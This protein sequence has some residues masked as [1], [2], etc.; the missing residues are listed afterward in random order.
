MWYQHTIVLHAK[1]RGF[2]LV[3]D[4]IIEKL[5]QLASVEV[6]ILHLLL[7]HLSYDYQPWGVLPQSVHPYL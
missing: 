2:H 6:G 4:E 7:Q 1:P 5:P 3:T